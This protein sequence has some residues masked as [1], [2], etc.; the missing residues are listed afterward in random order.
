MSSQSDRTR[1][2]IIGGATLALIA[3]IIG[4]MTAGGDETTDATPG[5]S[6]SAAVTTVVANAEG[7][8]VELPV[9]G[10]ATG[11]SE[12][13]SEGSSGTTEATANSTDDSA[14]TTASSITFSSSPAVSEGDKRGCEE[15][16]ILV[17]SNGTEPICQAPGAGCPDN[18]GVIGGVDG[19]LLCKG[20]EGDVLRIQP[21]GTVTV[22][23]SISF[24]GPVCQKS[25]ANGNV[26][27]LTLAVSEEDCLA[28]DG[29]YFPNGLDG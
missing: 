25:D 1:L 5:Q 16:L 10:E 3:S 17:G 22:D 29:Q 18:Y 24:N 20:P 2:A 19:A 26:L 15:G 23:S 12:A 21:D 7:G 9:T 11:S 4:F 28:R 13:T 27:E 6:D 8:D 14:A